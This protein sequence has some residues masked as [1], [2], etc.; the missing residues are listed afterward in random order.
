LFFLNFYW[1][2]CFIFKVLINS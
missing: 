1:K 2:I